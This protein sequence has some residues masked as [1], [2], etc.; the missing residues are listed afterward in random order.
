MYPNIEVCKSCKYHRGLECYDGTLH[1]CDLNQ[2]YP[3]DMGS[4]M[5]ICIQDKEGRIVELKEIK[6]G[7]DVCPYEL[8][9]LISDVK[10]TKSA[11]NTK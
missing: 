11:N 3:Y 8:E 9:Q 5:Q 1:F 10:W 7:K 4:S 6:K 2:G